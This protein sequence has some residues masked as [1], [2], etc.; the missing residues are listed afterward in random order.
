[1]TENTITLADDD[2]TALALRSTVR[3]AIAGD[4]KYTA[5]VEA[6]NVTPDNVKDYAAALAAFIF[7]NEEPVQKKDGKRTKYGNAVQKIAT[8]LRRALSS[9]DDAETEDKPVNLLT[10]AG[11]AADLEAVIAAWKAAHE[12]DE[13]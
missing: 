11:L 10:R 4:G 13:S 1:M 3:A 9:D 7:P 5:F 8:G 6:H 2:T 12:A